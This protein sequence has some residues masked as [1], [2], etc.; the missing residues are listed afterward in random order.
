M[1]HRQSTISEGR[2]SSAIPGW[3][4]GWL[5]ACVAWL[6]LAPGALA[7]GA[8]AKPDTPKGRYLAELQAQ[9][10]LSVLELRLEGAPTLEMTARVRRTLLEIDSADL[11]LLTIDIDAPFSSAADAVCEA[12][13]AIGE[14]VLVAAY[15]RRAHDA[16]ALVALAAHAIA[17][18]PDGSIGASPDGAELSPG[19]AAYLRTRMGQLAARSG[20]SAKL[21]AAIADPE[22]VLHGVEHEGDPR[23]LSGA[24]LAELADKGQEPGATVVLTDAG[25]RLRLGAAA[26]VRWG[27]AEATLAE[28]AILW[29]RWG[30]DVGSTHQ[31][32]RRWS[33]RLIGQLAQPLVLALLLGFGLLGVYIELTTPGFGAPGSV[34]VICLALL[35]VVQ[36]MCGAVEAAEIG[37]ITIGLLLLIV[38]VFLLPGFGV[39]G[40]LGLGCISLGGLL[41]FQ[42][43]AVPNSSWQQATMLNSTASLAGGLGVAIGGVLLLIRLMPHLPLLQR[44]ALADEQLASEGYIVGDPGEA[45]LIGRHG[46]A[47]T[48]LRPTGKITIDGQLHDVVCDGEFVEAQ[49]AVVVR[50]VRGNVIVV[51]RLVR[52]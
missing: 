52:G 15:V 33:D 19:D 2:S 30:L 1:R 20:I 29:D 16:G 12:V 3:L 43:F 7:Q 35:L 42:T 22:M 26:A 50:D 36:F 5:V 37:L 32:D 6:A 11:V 31:I 40:V 10:G 23:L 48:P 45:E 46:I 24:E 51:E 14:R 9:R 25:S 8:G 17:L 44:L 47:L 4:R 49:S 39:A 28:G 41:C 18:A 21:A 34:G 38:E 27:L 13:E